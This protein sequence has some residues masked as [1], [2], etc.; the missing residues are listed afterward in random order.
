MSKIFRLYKGGTNT[1]QGWNESP[2]FPYNST[3]RNSIVDPQGASVRNEITS[4]PSPFARIDLVKTAFMEVCRKDGNT[5]QANLDGGTIFHKMVSD[6]LDVGEIFFNIDKY[7]DKIEII[8]WNAGNELAALEDGGNEAHY[9]YADA[10][11]KYIKSDQKTYNFSDDMNI[12]LLNYL[13]GPDMYNIIGAT[14]PAT[15]FFSSANKLDYVKDIFFNQDKPFDKEYMPLYK[16]DKNYVKAWFTLQKNIPNFASLFPEL[17]EY[18][19]ETFKFLGDQNFKKEIS[20]LGEASLNDFDKIESQGAGQ[21]NQVDVLGYPILKKKMPQPGTVSA[22]SDFT[23]QPTVKGTADPLPLVLPTEA[24]NQ[25]SGL[26]YVTGTWG[27]SNRA[28]YEDNEKDYQKRT[29]P[30]D[31]MKGAYLTIS[32]FLEDTLISVNH[33][34]NSTSF[35]DGAIK[36]ENPQQAYLLPLKPLFFKFFTVESLTNPNQSFLTMQTRVGELGVKVSLRIP[37]KGNGKVSSIEY[38]R[39]YYRNSEPNIHKN[40]GSIKEF[41][42]TGLV[43]PM[44]KFTDPEKAYYTVACVTMFSTQHPFE[45]FEGGRKLTGISK[46]CRN[47][48]KGT[49][50]F[51]SENY[52]IQHSNFDYIQVSDTNGHKGIVLPLFKGQQHKEIFEFAVD[53]GTSNTH[54]E[55]K[56]EDGNSTPLTFTTKENLV[57]QMFNQTFDDNGVGIDLLDEISLI[58]KDFLPK[59]I[60]EGDARFP[61]RTALSCA[62]TIDWKNTYSPFELY[63]LALT[64]EKRRQFEYNKIISD[65]K[66]GNQATQAVMEAYVESLMWLIRSKVLL[67]GGDLSQTKVTWFYPISMPVKRQV[68]LRDTWNKM[69]Y[70]YFTDRTSTQEMTESAAPIIYYF[71]RYATAS[72][73]I[74]I[75]MGGGT[76]DVAFAHDKKIQYVTS[77]K[78]ATNVLFQDSYTVGNPHN[79]I[80]DWYKGQVMKILESKKINEPQRIY[81]LIGGNPADIA[82]FFFSLKDN[83]QI[84]ASGLKAEEIDFNVLLRRDDTFRIVFILYYVSI[85]YHIAQIVK[86]KKL[87]EPRH[88]SFSGN[89]SKIVNVLTT[90]MNTLAQF[91]K[92]IFEGVLGHP[93]SGELEILGFEKDSNPKEAT[94]KGGILRGI[95]GGVQDATRDSIII[96]K[97]DNSGIVSAEETYGDIDDAYIAQTIGE[98]KRFFDFALDTLNENFNYNDNFGISKD[99]LAMAKE[100]CQKDLDTFIRKG[101]NSCSDEDKHNKIEETIF[102][103]P[104]K[105]VINALSQAIYDMIS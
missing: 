65:I 18:L 1:Y 94:A 47:K 6:A 85:I 35:F 49:G 90:D 41:D 10:L 86:E 105:G 97:G 17:D 50:N 75:D 82:S 71:S 9:Y 44:V 99:S 55:C 103:Y 70:K 21:I 66:W 31:G 23:I 59:G 48:D 69:F 22:S 24:G 93:Y 88:I 61:T 62:K 101:I 34:L 83:S 91:T 38:I 72:D 84:K 81:K 30:F 92:K 100:L 39:T 74:N 63:N 26:Y 11:R 2:S 96:L 15:L 73:L 14:S 12:Y 40:E 5:G 32:D 87:K 16:R 102:F 7:Q 95:L 58:E 13:D 8:S 37:I 51:K 57:C 68:M 67:N 98:V 46:E 54:I 19:N 64:Y 36:N 27:T 78:Y 20:N 4:I 33:T 104:I 52:T 80:I 60:G 56:S 89:G 25:Y 43:M 28:P 29:L 53:L 45:F 3:T 76:T 79:G 77:F 42:F